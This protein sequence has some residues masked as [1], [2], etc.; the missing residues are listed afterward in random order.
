[1]ALTKISTDGVKDDAITKA[2]IPAN[3]IETSELAPLSVTN[4]ELAD[5][6][7]VQSKIGD[8]QVSLDKL[9]H[10]D[11]NNDGKFLRANNGADPSYETVD[12]A[13]LDAANLTTGTIPDARIPATLPAVSAANLTN[14]PA[15]NITGTLPAIDGS[16]LTGISAGAVRNLIINGE[17]LI[18]QRRQ[19]GTYSCDPSGGNPVYGTMDRWQFKNYYGEAGRYDVHRSNDVPGNYQHSIKIDVTTAQGT[20]SGNNY[21]SFAQNIEAYNVAHLGYG[22]S[23][24]KQLTLQFWIKST[25]TG[26]ASVALQR[27][28]NGR[29]CIKTYTISNSDTWEFKT[30]TFPADTSGGQIPHDNGKGLRV[31]FVLF[32]ARHSDTTGWHD[33][34]HFYSHSSQV[35]LIDSTSNNI[36]FTGIQLEVGDSASDFVHEDYS[37]MLL[38]CKRYYQKDI[39]TRAY[40]GSGNVAGRQF[41]V[42]F[43]VEM[44]NTPSINFTNT[45]VDGG[46]SFSASAASRQ[47]YNHYMSSS[48]RFYEWRVVAEA[49]L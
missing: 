21:A 1:M 12:L 27:D 14:L 36:Y 48:G 16:A 46:G 45:T 35:N 3:Q 10:G 44:R 11:S 32:S 25:K 5:G 22:T 17:F 30:V 6:S 4:L 15:A 38:K 34:S 20:P 40:W 41:P 26:T 9:P 2:K 7:V 43:E 13:N 23:N 8:Q 49:E 18:D 28:D 39:S 42:R 47:G 37:T 24:S 29:I 31:D 19:G 33:G